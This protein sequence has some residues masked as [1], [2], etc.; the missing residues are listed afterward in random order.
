MDLVKRRVK[1]D[2]IYHQHTFRIPP[3]ACSIFHASLLKFANISKANYLSPIKEISVKAL[4]A[5]YVFT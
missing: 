3:P 2:T 5:F 4:I 1:S